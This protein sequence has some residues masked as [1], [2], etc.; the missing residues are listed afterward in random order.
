MRILHFLQSLIFNILFF[1]WMSIISI[2]CLFAGYM[3]GYKGINR[4]GECSSSGVKWLL[5][6]IFGTTVEFR[7]K[8]LVPKGGQYIVACKHQSA[9]ETISLHRFIKDPTVVMK[10][11][12]TKV[13]IFGR[14][15]VN[16]GSIIIDRKKGKQMPQ[17]I[18]GARKSL[19]DGRPV[20]IF[21]EGTRSQAGKVGKYRYGIYALYKELNVPV[22]PIALNSGY[23]W[24]RRGF[25][26][27][28]GRIIVEYL[29]LIE[30]GL[31]Q[32][33]FMRHLEDTI[34]TASLALAPDKLTSE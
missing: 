33:E 30:P 3:K 17:L 8:G 7:N 27:K 21:P 34:E 5:R 20:F 31:S 4:V 16:A 6:L 32:N 24:P 1:V 18:E 14:V 25:M 19:D 28:K 2:W 10:K 9:W 11:E 15:I 29:P 22:L 13:P 12:L 26:K 23:V